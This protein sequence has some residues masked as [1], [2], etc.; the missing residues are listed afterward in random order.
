MKVFMYSSKFC[1]NPKLFGFSNGFLEFFLVFCHNN[2]PVK[3]LI[4]HFL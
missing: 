1:K 2:Q 4:V 3:P